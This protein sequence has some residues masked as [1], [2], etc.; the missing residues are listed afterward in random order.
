MVPDD[1]STAQAPRQVSAA[2]TDTRAHRAV[3]DSSTS[4]STRQ[5]ERVATDQRRRIGEDSTAMR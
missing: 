3:E 4:G 5:A 2:D 1:N